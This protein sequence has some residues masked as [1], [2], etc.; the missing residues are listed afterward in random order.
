MSKGLLR[1][2]TGLL[3]SGVGLLQL[4]TGLL[5][6]GIGLLQL[7]TGLLHSELHFQFHYAPRLLPHLKQMLEVCQQLLDCLLG[8]QATKDDCHKQCCKTQE[9]NPQKSLSTLYLMKGDVKTLNLETANQGACGLRET[10]N[11]P[12]G[13]KKKCKTGQK[14]SAALKR[15][16]PTQCCGTEG[17]EESLA[18]K[19]LQR[20]TKT[21]SNSRHDYKQHAAAKMWQI[22]T[23]LAEYNRSF[24]SRS[25]Y[26]QQKQNQRR[27]L[28]GRTLC[29]PEQNRQPAGAPYPGW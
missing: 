24:G 17:A 1:L 25:G 26:K 5:H 2:G 11:S 27:T 6:S 15:D 7:G 23:K 13:K 20:G 16:R 3:L 8:Q 4:G 14:A 18:L 22:C 29:R 19:P 21:K 10:Y 12:K 9:C 28:R